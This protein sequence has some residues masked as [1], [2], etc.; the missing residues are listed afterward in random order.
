MKKM[1]SFSLVLV[2]L[3]STSVI[4]AS[5]AQSTNYTSVPQDPNVPGAEVYSFYKPSD[6]EE[7]Y[8]YAYA[9]K[10]NIR[11]EAENAPYPGEKLEPEFGDRYIYSFSV[12]F[13]EYLIFNGGTNTPLYQD[14]FEE[15]LLPYTDGLNT[16]YYDEWYSYSELYYYT[17]GEGS[18]VF[19]GES[20]PDYVLIEACTYT[21]APIDVFAVFGN[22]MLHDSHGSPHMLKYYIYTP[23]DG[24][25]YTLDKAIEAEIDGVMN[26]FADYGLGEL[27]GDLD[28]DRK[29]TIK[30]ATYL[31]KCL[32]NY[33]GFEL[34]EEKRGLSVKD[35]N[36][37]D[38]NLICIADF[39]QNDKINIKDSTAIQK[40][41]AKV[42]DTKKFSEGLEKLDASTY[43]DD[44][45]IVTVKSADYEDYTLE[46]FSEYE[47]SSIEK[48]GSIY[49]KTSPATY[50]LYLKNPS[51]ENV[52]EAIKALD[53]RADK[54]L[55][56]VS[57]NAIAFAD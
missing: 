27:M 48:I 8:V 1:L 17:D 2:L 31:Q 47:F 39:D 12:G 37:P 52:I 11:G 46:D 6:R 53:Y 25:I 16:E 24:Q 29:L 38:K 33:K 49:D 30:D 44:S 34:P 56:Y 50:V 13:Y 19:N 42:S 4:F 32:A 55:M 22:Y 10:E 9:T 21:S 20:T 14:V 41:L 5:A 18:T 40:K 43:E 3:L 23:E 35:D 57:V 36:S 7:V 28:G 26:V 45:I 54:D 51:H 15:Y